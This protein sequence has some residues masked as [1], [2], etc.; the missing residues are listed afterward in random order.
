MYWTSGGQQQHLSCL[1]CRPLPAPPTE[2]DYER[3]KVE[4][5]LESRA[6][7]D[8]SGD[9]FLCK[10]EGAA[11][12]PRLGLLPALCGRPCL[13]VGCWL[14][15]YSL[16]LAVAQACRTARPS[17]FPTMCCQ[18]RRPLLPAGCHQPP[19]LHRG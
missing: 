7:G 16:R 15:A 6:A 9:E 10:F 5:I 11:C 1:P 8:G 3:H 13:L 4:K 17:G 14:T 2:L 12:W 19:V 18:A